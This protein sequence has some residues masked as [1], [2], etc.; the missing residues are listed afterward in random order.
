MR[1]GAHVSI[2]GGFALA[3]SRARDSGCDAFQIFTQSPSRWQGGAVSAEA[4]S[5]FR[6][7]CR[8]AGYD[9]PLG[10]ASYLI[11]LASPDPVVWSRSVEALAVEME[12]AESLG[13]LCLVTHPGCHMGGGTSPG[14]S[15][16]SRAIDRVLRGRPDGTVSL[17][18]EN[19][20]GQGS[21]VGRSFDELHAIIDGVSERRRVAVCLD[22]CHL[23]AAG[24]DL[25]TRAGVRRALREFDRTI[26]LDRLCAVHVNDSRKPAGSRIDRHAHVGRGTIGL[27]GFY[28]L[29]HSRPLRGLPM[30]LE[31]PKDG[32][33]DRRNLAVLRSLAAARSLEEGVAGA[34][35][36]ARAAAG[37]RSVGGGVRSA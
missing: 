17:A 13:L 23:H 12:R 25:S 30:I 22:T 7:A 29:L 36:A 24:H 18:L 8:S 21:A 33:A 10:H 35:R 14:I 11:N 20:A 32:D 16:V 4:A 28:A 34:R 27:T 9:R 37:R 6:E 26:G 15:R 19:T 5:A 1:F 3:V 31:T 2:A